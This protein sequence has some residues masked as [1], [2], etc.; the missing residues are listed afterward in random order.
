MNQQRLGII[1]IL[2]FMISLVG[3]ILATQWIA[4][5]LGYVTQFLGEPIMVDHAAGMSI[6]GPWKVYVWF[7]AYKGGQIDLILNQAMAVAIGSI[8]VG[9]IAGLIVVHRMFASTESTAHGSSRWADAEE[10]Q[11]RGLTRTPLE[12]ELEIL[13]ADDPKKS[14]HS[15]ASV[16]L[17]KDEKGRHFYDWGPEHVMVFAPTRSGKGVGLIIPTLYTWKGS[18]IVTDLKGENYRK[19]S[20]YR[21]EFSHILYFNPTSDAS[22]R[23][24]PLLE[25]RTGD[26]AIQDVGDLC[27]ILV[28]DA[29][30]GSLFWTAGGKD[31]LE[32][33]LLYVLHACE[34][35]TLGHALALLY[36]E[37]HLIE[38]LLR[39][40]FDND[41]IR[42]TVHGT[43]TK[44][45]N[46]TEK[47][48]G[49]WTATAQNALKLWKDPFV[50]RATSTS[51]FRLRDLQF[52]EHPL[53]LYLVIPPGS[54]KRLE[55]LV[56]LLFT[57]II[58]AL[59]R[60]EPVDPR[61]L[62]MLCDEL[63]MF[64]KIPKVEL[65]MSYTASYGIK[66]FII[67]QGLEQFD[68]FYGEHNMFLINCHTR[69]AYPCNDDKTAKRLSEL[70]GTGT[71]RKTQKGKSGKNALLASATNKSETDLEYSRYLMTPG[72]LMQ[73]AD[74][75]IIIMQARHWPI[76][77]YKVTYYDDP[78]FKDRYVLIDL[79]DERPEDF[80]ESE[81]HQW[82]QPPVPVRQPIAPPT[83]DVTEAPEPKPPIEQTPVEAPMDAVL[84]MNTEQFSAA[85]LLA[86]QQKIDRAHEQ[87]PVEDAF[88]T[89]DAPDAFTPSFLV[90]DYQGKENVLT[91]AV[92]REVL[93]SIMQEDQNNQENQ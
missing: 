34:D 70:L 49:G 24:N 93:M 15:T 54:I 57:Q 72:E 28:D 60:E 3:H 27:E 87:A 20:E 41:H 29:D 66:W 62:L 23:F 77:G 63:P 7:A 43:A 84:K 89:P 51:D 61:R 5:Q 12:R 11:Q 26:Y 90:D 30:K 81:A 85:D 82:V 17:G 42:L 69:L 40:E 78:V 10:I 35:K 92:P 45:K 44:F 86:L 88:V 79:P 46:Q 19:T 83:P 64:G 22:V 4:H 91:E 73:F 50:C 55:P 39:T 9:V 36:D 16:V 75:R 18:V 25:V 8:C 65:S 76:L 13:G 56:C 80:P 1:C 71:A 67:C 37:E 33:T 6:Y 14:M 31:I 2:T 68:M 47:I 38:T 58:D 48:R 53:S 59:T 32:A 74:D 21:S 52:A